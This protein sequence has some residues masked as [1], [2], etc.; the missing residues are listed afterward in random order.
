MS[1]IIRGAYLLAC[2]FLAGLPVRAD[3]IVR[4]VA[5]GD[6]QP[7]ANVDVMIRP[8]GQVVVGYTLMQNG[9]RVWVS[10]LEAGGTF[11]HAHGPTPASDA[12]FGMDPFGS[13]HYVSRQPFSA[14][15]RVGVDLGDWGALVDGV[16]PLG[17]HQSVMP[18]IA[19]DSHAIPAIAAVNTAGQP[20]LARFDPALGNW[21]MELTVDRGFQQGVAQSLAVDDTGR[22]FLASIGTSG[23]SELTIAGRDEGEMWRVISAGAGYAAMGFGLAGG[24]EGVGF[25]YVGPEGLTFGT[26]DGRSIS[27]ELIGGMAMLLPRSIAFDPAGNPAIA[28]VA[29]G[30]SAAG[31]VHLV[32]RDEAGVWTDEPLP[33]NAYRATVAF[34][35]AGNPFIAAAT[36]TGIALVGKTLPP[37]NRG[38]LVGSIFAVPD[39]AIDHHDIDAIVSRI[40]KPDSIY[41]MDE[42]GQV[43]SADADHL[44]TAILNC[45][46]GDASL[47]GRLDGDDYYHIDSGF[48]AGLGGYANGDFDHD[49]IISAR[50]YHRIDLAF[51]EVGTLAVLPATVP[52]PLSLQAVLAIM[53]L[54]IR[55]RRRSSASI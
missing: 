14:P 9:G 22:L 20:Y 27:T 1:R 45:P 39:G 18:A 21:T 16:L 13:I 49:G 44:I 19:V 43:T 48:L 2:T 54:L 35:A 28:Y 33:L 51:L 37:V 30:P 7:T 29:G 52:E 25:A 47:D 53:S 8:D 40:G 36:A 46:I 6:V 10:R 42:D 38:D 34:D 23:A 31:A 32:R 55:R 3:W 26:S 41:D 12:A 50:D 15:V 4:P 5:A 17:V 24:T 11:E